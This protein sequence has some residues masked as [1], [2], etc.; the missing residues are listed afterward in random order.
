MAPTPDNPQTAREVQRLPAAILGQAEAVVFSDPTAVDMLL[1][2]DYKEFRRPE[3]G[4]NWLLEILTRPLRRRRLTETNVRR[5]LENSLEVFSALVDDHSALN[6]IRHETVWL[7]T[8]NDPPDDDV[9]SG[10]C[11]F[12]GGEVPVVICY[13]QTLAS[14]FPGIAHEI[15]WQGSMDHFVGHLYPYF[16]GADSPDDYD[17]SVACRYQHLAAK[18]RARTDR[19]FL[20]VARLIPL[21]YKLHKDIPLSNYRWDRAERAAL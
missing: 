3:K 15:A 2:E 16:R 9:W 12:D 13:S 4:I 21:V 18:H 20:A 6:R 11:R 19:R 10:E 14:R 17:E 7:V 1:S 5:W 8:D